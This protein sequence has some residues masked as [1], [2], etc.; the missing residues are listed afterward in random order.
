MVA[1]AAGAQRKNS[2]LLGVDVNSWDDLFTSVQAILPQPTPAPIPEP[3]G[4]LVPPRGTDYIGAYVDPDDATPG[5]ALTAQFESEIGRTLA[6]NIHYVHWDG[7]FPNSVEDD[8]VAHDRIPLIS[9]HCGD[10]NAHIER[11]DD[12]KLIRA[13]A[14][15]IRAFGHPLFLRYEWEMNLSALTDVRK[16]CYDPKTDLRTGFFSPPRYIA[17]WKRIRS[18]FAAEGA[19]NVIWLWNPGAGGPDPAQYYPGD[20]EV[21]WV[22][23]DSYDRHDYTFEDTFFPFL[24]DLSQFRK[25]MMIVETGAV[26]HFQKTFFRPSLDTLRERYPLVRGFSY[27]DAH[28][29]TNWSLTRKGIEGF[30]KLAHTH[31][32]SARQ[33]H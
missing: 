20:D 5:P 12:D 27:L 7:A 28:S 14:D 4:P 23:L 19:N 18:I 15:A 2:R 13:H 33:P 32:M 26:A 6:Y 3:T 17:A 22:G 21:D 9:W 31:F 11:G 30:K 29:G 1:L 10:T 8:D 24:D 16:P 25:P